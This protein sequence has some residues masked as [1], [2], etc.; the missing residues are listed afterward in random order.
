[1][2]VDDQMAH[3]A[4]V[5]HP[6]S[7]FD[8][9]LFASVGEDGKGMTV[10]VVSAL[11]RLGFDPRAEAAELA[12]LPRDGAERE[13]AAIVGKLPEVPAAKAEPA[14]IAARLIALLPTVAA[15]ARPGA[16]SARHPLAPKYVIL[17]LLAIALLLGAQNFAAIERS[18]HPQGDMAAPVGITSSPPPTK[19]NGSPANGWRARPNPLSSDRDK[20]DDN[21][22]RDHRLDP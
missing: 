7:E 3:S 1:M 15:N 8:G 4:S 12:R 17:W 14:R 2:K 9:F 18:Q 19:S 22:R 13:L 10:S 16:T 20:S 5:L 21:A 11:A 6:E